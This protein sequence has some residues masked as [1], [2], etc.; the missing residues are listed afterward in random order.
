MVK[1]LKKLE[2][3][4]QIIQELIYKIAEKRKLETWKSEQKNSKN[5]TKTDV[6]FENLKVLEISNAF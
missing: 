3:S 4:G 6:K 1:K 2:I 5:D